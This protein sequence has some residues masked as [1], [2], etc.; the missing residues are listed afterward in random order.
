MNTNL[1]LL[2][3]VIVTIFS[4]SCKEKSGTN[5]EVNGTIA[6]IE[7][8]A[9][10][11]PTL[12]RK[13]SLKVFLYEVP[14]GNE[15]PPVQLD[16]A[17]VTPKNNSF[18]LSA[19][20]QHIGMIDV[21][22]ENG[23]MI[24]LVNDEEKVTVMIDLDS[25]DNFYSV[26]GSPASQQM[27]DFIMG[28]TEKSNAAETA[29]KNLDSLK[30]RSSSDSVL[31]GATNQ[32]NSSLEAMNSYSKQFLSTVNHPVVAAFILGTSSATL[33]VNE[34][35]T[36]LNKQLQKYPSD[37]S[38]TFLKKQFDARKAQL[39]QRDANMS[40]QQ[41]NSWVGKKA[42][43]L[44]LPD[45]NGKDISLDA[46]KGKY[47]LVDF[48]ASWCKPCREEN[49]NVVKAFNEF[50][51]KNFTILGVSLDREKASW[52]QAIQDDQLAW[53]HVSDL[54]FWD[55]KAVQAYKFEGIPYNVLIDPS[56]TI[57]AENLRGNALSGKLQEVLQ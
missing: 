21:M 27:R 50:K 34:L 42:P 3:I 32:K 12:F 30:L 20:V 41:Q 39:A 55:S 38:L 17:Y 26:K 25:R 48:W 52:L 22:L 13:D 35:E 47:V 18:T 6:N 4:F 53:T 31:L 9:S 10:Q 44:T 16:S 51:N 11:Y 33:P 54:A 28:Y 24:P 23:P 14:F 19:N 36:E 37:Q 1:K 15:I 43:Q 46:F 29:F 49:P 40:Q 56:G 8:L 57:I 5:F 45:Q 2:M 7:K